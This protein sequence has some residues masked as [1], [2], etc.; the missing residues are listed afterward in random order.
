MRDGTASNDRV[1]SVRV[2]AGTRRRGSAPRNRTAPLTGLTGTSLELASAGSCCATSCS[3]GKWR[4]SC[5]PDVMLPSRQAAEGKKERA[6]QIPA[7]AVLFLA[8]PD[9]GEAPAEIPQNAS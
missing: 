8:V 3:P 6:P 9:V 7:A 1:T 2:T 4:S 5:F